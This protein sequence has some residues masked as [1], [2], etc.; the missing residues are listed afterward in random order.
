MVQR[1]KQK[2]AIWGEW[3]LE[4]RGL[5]GMGGQ[6]GGVRANRIYCIHSWNDQRVNWTNQ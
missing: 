4:N 6:W 5:I 3:P 1:V 2:C